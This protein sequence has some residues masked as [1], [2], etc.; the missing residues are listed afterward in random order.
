M[1]NRIAGAFSRRG[2]EVESLTVSLNK[3]KALFTIIVN[4]TDRVL[5]Q[6]VEQLNKPVNVLKVSVSTDLGFIK[7]WN[8]TICFIFMSRPKFQMNRRLAV[9][10]SEMN[11]VVVKLYKVK[12]KFVLCLCNVDLSIKYLSGLV[13]S[14]CSRNRFASSFISFLFFEKKSIF[15]LHYIMSKNKCGNSLP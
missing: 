6:L 12:I 5:Q 11:L 14:P 7:M 9:Q 3:D 8:I 10:P 13:S 15:C 1:I 2:Y 4:G